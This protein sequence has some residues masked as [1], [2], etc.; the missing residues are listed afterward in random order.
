M[1]SLTCLI[2]SFAKL[3]KV[4]NLSIRFIFFG[5]VGE[6]SN[7]VILYYSELRSMFRSSL[8]NLQYLIDGFFDGF[9]VQKPREQVADAEAL[10]DITTT[11]VSSVKAHGNEGITP[12]DLVN[13]LLRDFGRQGQGGA[14]SS[15]EDSNNSVL[16]KD[17]GLAVS[18]VFRRAP[19]CTT[20]YVY[21]GILLFSFDPSVN[22]RAKSTLT[23][24]V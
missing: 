13:S 22:F 1:N 12:S 11:L 2:C 18:H 24:V 23:F 14:S 21:S 19:G 7:I 9:S 10:F 20:M 15:T 16:W 17:I 4:I 6:N 5:Y 3:N 8:T